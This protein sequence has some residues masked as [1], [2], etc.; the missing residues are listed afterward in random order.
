MCAARQ[1]RPLGLPC[2]LLRQGGRGQLLMGTGAVRQTQAAPQHLEGQ[3]LLRATMPSVHLWP[4]T[5][6][7]APRRIVMRVGM[8]Q[9]G[10]RGP[11][12]QM[13]CAGWL[14]SSVAAYQCEKKSRHGCLRTKHL[15]GG[16][17]LSMT[18]PAT[19]AV[20]P[21]QGGCPAAKASTPSSNDATRATFVASPRRTSKGIGRPPG[22]TPRGTAVGASTCTGTLKGACMV[23]D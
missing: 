7:K 2:R 3:Q 4:L 8:A 10:A 12:S 17:V 21:R 11:V 22:P 23:F 14:S 16:P 9:G 13:R 6:A 15:V 19:G 18:G 5:G 1:C 20:I